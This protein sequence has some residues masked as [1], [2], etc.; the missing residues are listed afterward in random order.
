MDRSGD[1]SKFGTE[2]VMSGELDE[3]KQSLSASE[4]LKKEDYINNN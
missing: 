4:E 1:W 3:S 2:I